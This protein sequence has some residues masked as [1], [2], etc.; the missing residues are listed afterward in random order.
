[1]R[2][3]SLIA[4]VRLRARLEFS[5]PLRLKLALKTAAACL[6]SYLAARGLGFTQ[7]YWAV[8]SAFIIVQLSLADTVRKGLLRMAGTGA[9]GLLGVGLILLLPGR[10]Y[11]SA[12]AISIWALILFS[13]A[14]MRR[15]SYAVTISVVTPFLVILAGA[16]GWREAMAVA[17]D[18]SA[19]IVLGVGIAWVILAR[20]RPVDEGQELLTAC[21][22]MVQGSLA[23]VRA[24]LG[25]ATR[26]EGRLEEIR[27]RRLNRR[28][29]YLRMRADFSSRPAG[30]QE[31]IGAL[32][33]SLRSL[34]SYSFHL[35]ENFPGREN[36]SAAPR[37]GRELFRFLDEIEAV[38]PRRALEFIAAR[39]AA[40]R[41]IRDG[42]EKERLASVPAR[43]KIDRSRTARKMF[44][45]YL[46]ETLGE[47]AETMNRETPRDPGERPTSTAAPRN[48]TFDTALRPALKKTA[49][50]LISALAWAVPLGN[51]QAVISATLIAGQ[52]HQSASYRRAFYR[53]VGTLLGAATALALLAASGGGEAVFVALA[54]LDEQLG[55]VYP[56]ED[57]YSTE[58]LSF[59]DQ[60][61]WLDYI[62]YE[63]D[64]ASSVL[65]L[66]P[67]TGPL[68]YYA[69]E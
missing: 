69:G 31:R 37:S 40:I 18:R 26:E 28:I 3:G 50:I 34:L 5:D 29:E 21:G 22:K 10:P 35:E 45:F 56:V 48:R 32:L 36:P 68:A 54:A 14:G 57:Y 12:T 24:V 33:T 11:L 53:L 13:V 47:I 49:A 41:R 43:G 6:V 65:R 38:P 17:F 30:T 66:L 15:Y 25:G 2:Q 9:G 63:G 27:L 55:D 60:L 59:W 61:N 64:E 46:A 39:H 42:L 23:Y 58:E 7:A 8:I 44:L 20:I 62:H 67:P 1:M 51:V 16:S 52:A 19:T 4:R